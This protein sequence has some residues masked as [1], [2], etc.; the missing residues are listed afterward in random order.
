MVVELWVQF[1]SCPHRTFFH[2]LWDVPD[3]IPSFLFSPTP[4]F[5]PITDVPFSCCESDA[6]CGQLCC[7]PWLR[8]VPAT[9]MALTFLCSCSFL[10]RRLSLPSTWFARSF[11]SPESIGDVLYSFVPIAFTHFCLVLSP[12]PCSRLDQFFF[13]KVLVL[14]NPASSSVACPHFPPFYFCEWVRSSF[15]FSLV[16]HFPGHVLPLIPH[17]YFSLALTSFH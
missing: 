12:Q 10:I 13:P 9:F 4:F 3:A 11:N 6:P 5:S 16:P 14:P 7:F 17:F 2:P 15:F 8:E 1:G